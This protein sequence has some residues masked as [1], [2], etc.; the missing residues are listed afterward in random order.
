[1]AP[2]FKAWKRACLGLQM[3]T[4]SLHPVLWLLHCEFTTQYIV[5]LCHT[6]LVQSP[7]SLQLSMAFSSQKFGWHHFLGF[8]SSV[9]RLQSQKVMLQV[10]SKFG[11]AVD[12]FGCST[13][14]LEPH[15]AARAAYG[16]A[17]M[18]LS[19]NLQPKLLLVVDRLIYEGQT[20]DLH[21]LH[22]CKVLSLSGSLK[23]TN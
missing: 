11:R 13:V 10:R 2:T 3:L 5:T 23:R 22:Y 8:V 12:R 21:S 7:G 19:P 1:M 17:P 16:L 4:Y 14:L 18:Q 15:S 20:F 6:W 9:L